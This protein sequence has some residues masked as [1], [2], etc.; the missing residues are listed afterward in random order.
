MTIQQHQD[1]KNVDGQ[2]NIMRFVTK[3]AVASAYNISLVTILLLIVDA[4]RQ[5][6]CPYDVQL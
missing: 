3:K 1:W 4:E 2:L 5:S 6:F